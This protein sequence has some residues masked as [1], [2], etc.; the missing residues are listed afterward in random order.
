MS[1]EVWAIR[2]KEGFPTS[3]DDLGRMAMP[4]WSKRT[5]AIAVVAKVHDYRNFH[6][7]RLPLEAFMRNW[8]PGLAKDGL[9]VGVNWSGQ[10]ATGYDMD[11]RDVLS[12]LSFLCAAAVS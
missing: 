2:D 6:A 7:E 11:P 8:L 10:Q 12:R 4:F 9:W 5:R 3:T 1:G